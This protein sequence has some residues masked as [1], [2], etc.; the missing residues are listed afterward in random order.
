MGFLLHKGIVKIVIRCCLSSTLRLK[1]NPFNVTAIQVYASTLSYDD[2]ADEEFYTE[3][4][5][6][7][8]LINK[9]PKQDILVVQAEWKTHVKNCTNSLWTFL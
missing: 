9:I 8:Y 3:I 2:N 6:V 5:Y 1:A 4:R 7:Q